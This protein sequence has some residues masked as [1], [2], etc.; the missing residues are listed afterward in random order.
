MDNIKIYI[1]THKDFI[2]IVHSNSYE[3][4][5]SRNITPNLPLKDDFYSE[6]YQFKW[7]SEQDNLPQYVG[8]CHY[9]RYFAFL[10]EIPSLT[11]DKAIATTPMAFDSTVYDHYKHFHNIEDLDIISDIIDTK[12]PQYKLTKD[13]FLQG[14]MFI[15]NNMVIMHRDK[16]K[17]YINFIMTILDEYLK[18]V[19]T[20]IKDR[21]KR[22]QDKYIKNF[23]PNNTAEYQYRI[24]GFLGERCTN[25]FLMKNFKQV[26]CYDQIITEE[27]YEKK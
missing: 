24:G 25:I 5:D 3:T 23:Y 6:F 17:E 21:I 13:K 20:D 27:K 1:C 14:N 10:D 9:R 19:G 4:I 8:F 15:P 2:P 16:F 7:L 12:F 22:N 11:K 26:D 18:R